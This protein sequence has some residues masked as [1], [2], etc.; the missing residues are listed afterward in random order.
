MEKPIVWI[1]CFVS[2]AVGAGLGFL[3]AKTTHY[4][5]NSGPG[6]TGASVAI[7]G[8]SLPAG[9]ATA[10]RSSSQSGRGVGTGGRRQ[11]IDALLGLVNPSN[12]YNV[13]LYEK[14]DQL[15][16]AG[17]VA[18]AEEMEDVPVNDNRAYQVRTALFTR[19]AQLDPDAAWLATTKI[20]N[21]GLK[22]AAMNAVLGVIARTDFQAARR[23]VDGLK[24][25]P[26]KLAAM[27]GIIAGGCK[28][29]PALVFE[30][31]SQVPG[32]QAGWQF[33]QLFQQ[34]ARD[35]PEAAIAKLSEIQGQQQRAQAINGLVAGLAAT[36]PDRAISIAKGLKNAN[37]RTQAL[38]IAAANIATTNPQRALEMLD[39]VPAGNQRRQVIG[40][41]ASSWSSQDASAVVE[42]IQSL[43]PGDRKAAMDNSIW[44]IAQS[45]PRAAAEM[46]GSLP[47]SNN[48]ANLFQNVASQWAEYDSDAAAAWVETLAVGAGRREAVNGL[49]NAWQNN[50]PAKAAALLSKEGVT[51]NS[52]YLA[53]NVFGNWVTTN[54]EAA[55]AWIDGLELGSDA[56]SNVVSSAV[57]QWAQNDSAAAADYAIGIADEKV[58]KQAVSSLMGSWGQ[59]DPAAAKDWALS[60][61]E[62]DIKTESLSTL[63]QN[64]ANNDHTLALELYAETTAKLTD[65][66]IN[67]SFGAVASNIAGSWG[68]YDGAGAA[69][70]AMDLPEGDQRGRSIQSV[71]RSWS[72]AD[73]VAASEFVG[74]LSNGSERDGAVESLV[75]S[76]QQGDPESAFIWA[77]SISDEQK[78]SNVV[79]NAAMQWKEVDADA[80]FRA[81][82]NANIPDEE[83]V[84]LLKG[85]Q[86]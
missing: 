67:K 24:N 39:D 77:E 57:Q 75:L 35:Q 63:I 40:N 84:Q 19:W 20:E 23:M 83:K 71:V 10:T 8:E 86:E 44:Q 43:S 66:E 65:E 41:I 33:H 32:Q 22:G 80:A 26:A 76:V 72:E 17:I 64:L 82:G 52:S 34:W 79:R 12:G 15:D 18:L 27:N 14:M 46:V 4:E 48:N 62:G 50:D 68:Q 74:A 6:G 38:S 58:R 5:D 11:N 45:D 3:V 69:E 56:K 28:Q 25:G 42:W 54:R 55:V 73:P 31:V 85:M 81:V 47:A 7:V 49:V 21:T 36:D 13:E 37:E 70:W 2:L 51:N 78:R 9:G 59:S 1:A 29:N 61:L 30:M 16:L 60:N 53:G